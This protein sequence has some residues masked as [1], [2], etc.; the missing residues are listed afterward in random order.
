VHDDTIPHHELLQCV[1]RRVVDRHVLRLVK[2]WLHV[3]VE[4]RDADGRRRMTGG[5]RS[6]R[7]T[8]QGGVISPL[9]ANIYMH[10]FLRA[11]RQ[12]DKGRE[13]RAHLITYADDF[14]IVS[15]GQAAAAL[16]WTRGVMTRI[17]LTLNDAKTCIR[18]AR[19]EPFDF[20]GYT[21]GP[22]HY[23]KNG[24][25]YLAALR[26]GNHDR[27]SEVSAD[28]NRRLRG[29]ATYFSYGTRGLAYRAIDHYVAD[30]VCHFLRRRH[31]V[32]TRG[33]RRF[34]AERVFGA[35]GVLRLESLMGRSPG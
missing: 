1:A 13:Y 23:R 21:F 19:T 24:H 11:W 20:L 10:R 32:P 2:M 25:G 26:P 33:T 22:D 6:T 31:Q 8:P 7:G 16:A 30:A 35:L 17:G 34:G 4:E 14:V 18:N 15:R 9:L 27:W 29:W 28:L 12:R 5:T 3:P